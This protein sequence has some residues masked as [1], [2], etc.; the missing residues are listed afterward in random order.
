MKPQELPL[1]KNLK[2]IES[3][4]S[5]N[6][7]TIISTP[8]GSGKTLLVPHLVWTKFNNAKVFVTFPRVL[9]AKKAKSGVDD[10]LIGTS[11]LTGI[12]TSKQKEG[13]SSRLVFCTE[14]SFCN[15][16]SL[17]KSDILIVDEVHEQGIN[18]ELVLYIAKM[19]IENGGKVI[20]M[21]ATMD[22][23]RYIEFF[24]QGVVY[25]MP[26]PKRPYKTQIIKTQ[27]IA[28]A[29]ASLAKK[30]L[31]GVAGK[32]D[33]EGVARDLKKNKWNY[34]IFELHSEIEEEDEKKIFQCKGPC[35]IIATSI[36]MSGIT[37]KDLGVVVPPSEGKRIEDG[38]L[39]HYTLSLA[40]VKQWEGRVGRVCDGV[41]I[42]SNREIE[43]EPNPT[44]EILRA[45]VDDVVLSFAA[46]GI[47]LNEVKLL[48]QP[49][50]DKVLAS[51]K[52]LMELEV[53]QSPTKLTE[54]GA[55]ISSLGVGLVEG[56][57]IYKGIELGIEA[58]TRKICALIRSGSPYRK[59]DSG[60]FTRLIG[61]NEI[62]NISEHYKY[63]AAI[64]LDDKAIFAKNHGLSELVKKHGEENGIFLR[65]ANKLFK[66]FAKIDAEHEDKTPPTKEAIQSLFLAQKMGLFYDQQ[67]K[68]VG[69]VVSRLYGSVIYCTLSP[70]KLKY[71]RLAEMTTVCS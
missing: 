58:T 30:T 63:L 24:G 34:P 1:A 29:I 68:E 45:E 26:E 14:G 31:I 6:A 55:F 13:L 18:T 5:N 50:A 71:G 10:L 19:H 20:L 44:A 39:K 15:R 62:A 64:Q 48:N 22:C 43:R 37:F 59:T 49:P 36:A 25:E 42:Y 57:F 38:I 70:V 11:Y 7:L 40:E 66:D 41:A 69:R 67:N 47:N 32:G 2:Q 3:I 33:M 28:A 4:I 65:A 54:K 53:L 51:Q 9:L 17:A 23:K 52:K 60:Y 46:R 21:S 35:A 27:D 12:M 8:T 16:V 56:C 61:D